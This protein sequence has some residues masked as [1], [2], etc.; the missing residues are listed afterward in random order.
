[1]LEDKNWHIKAPPNISMNDALHLI[2][3]HEKLHHCTPQGWQ[4]VVRV[5]LEGDIEVM[6]DAEK[7]VTRLGSEL[8]K[9]DLQNQFLL[10]EMNVI[11]CAF[12]ADAEIKRDTND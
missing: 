1:M 3:Q 11:V 2:G 10:K 8:E 9:W 5:C 4:C 7:L 6:P 12:K